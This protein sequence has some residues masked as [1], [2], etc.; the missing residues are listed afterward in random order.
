MDITGW[1][2]INIKYDPD[3]STGDAMGLWTYQLESPDGTVHHDFAVVEYSVPMTLAGMYN[4]IE[5]SVYEFVER[6]VKAKQDAYK[7]MQVRVGEIQF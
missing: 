2:A 5:E 7:A 3:F 6:Q 1:K 4:R